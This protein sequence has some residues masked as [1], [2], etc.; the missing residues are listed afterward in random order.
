MLPPPEIVEFFCNAISK[1]ERTAQIFLAWKTFGLGDLSREG[2][3]TP[4]SEKNFFSSNLCA[5]APLR[6]LFRISLTGFPR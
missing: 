2:A 5:L 6:E 4:S 3:K 1:F